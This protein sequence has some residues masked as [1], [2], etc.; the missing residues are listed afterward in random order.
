MGTSL[1]LRDWTRG[2]RWLVLG[3]VAVVLVVVAGPVDAAAR[4]TISGDSVPSDCSAGVGVGSIAL[5]GDLDGCLTFFVDDY[6]CDELNGFD[7]YR[8]WGTEHFAGTFWGESGEFTTTY[9]LEATYAEGFCD[10]VDAG[11]FPFELQLTGGCDHRITGTSGVFD[12]VSG[13]ITFFDVIPDPG[14]S[15]AS[16]YL[17]AGY[18]QQ[19]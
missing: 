15:G 8:E 18:L 1:S 19:R 2:Q 4:R 14:S 9:T 3:V 7:R 16:N 17:Y 10:A 11:G 13:L 12:G 6:R 5:S